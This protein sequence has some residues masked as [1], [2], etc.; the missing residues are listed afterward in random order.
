M[1]VNSRV[2]LTYAV[3]LLRVLLYPTPNFMRLLNQYYSVCLSYYTL[4]NSANESEKKF[5]MTKLSDL[6]LMK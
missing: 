3:R 4:K 1:P 2:N 5:G 6:R